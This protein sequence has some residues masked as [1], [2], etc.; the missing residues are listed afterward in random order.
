SKRDTFRVNLCPLVVLP[1]LLLILSEKLNPNPV[2][3][4]GFII[5]RRVANYSSSGRNGSVK[6]T[7]F[8]LK[9]FVNPLIGRK[10]RTRWP[11]DNNFYEA[12]ITDYKA[13]EDPGPS[14]LL[15]LDCIRMRYN[16]GD[17]GTKV[18]IANEHNEVS[19]R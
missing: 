11:D 10:V 3:F 15:L 4:V 13:A 9:P 16:E 2:W 6:G 7:V 17:S 5:W 1:Y 8:L 12:V 18:M 19:K 14:Q